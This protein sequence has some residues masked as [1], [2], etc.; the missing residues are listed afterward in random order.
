MDGA[1][2]TKTVSDSRVVLAQHM[3]V[4]DSNP[5]GAVHGGTIMKLVDT[6]GGLAAMKFSGSPAVT[7]AI[8]ELSF[9]EPVNLGDLVTVTASVNGVGDTSMEVGVKVETENVLTGEKRHTATAYLLYV[10]VDAE[11]KQPVRVPRLTTESPEER[12]RERQAKARRKAR[13][14]RRESILAAR[15]DSEQAKKRR[16]EAKEARRQARMQAAKLSAKADAAAATPGAAQE[17]PPGSGESKPKAEPPAAS[18]P[19]RDD[20]KRWRRK[21]REAEPALVGGGREAEQ[22]DLTRWRR[23][24]G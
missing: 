10:A 8:D 5:A 21:E 7:A 18:A 4:S 11:T 22:V 24:S 17:G 20:I 9:L 12:R 2:T 6:A 16:A 15:A 3:G 23:R 14:A 1:E 19:S 13:I